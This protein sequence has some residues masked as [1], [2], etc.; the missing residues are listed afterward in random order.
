M[1]ES[2][3]DKLIDALSGETF[4]EWVKRKRRPSKFRVVQV[5]D[6]KI[7]EW[8]IEAHNLEEAREIV[9]ESLDIII[10]PK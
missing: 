2:L 8:D 9:L 4:N 10:E 7:N 6:D 1:R 3:G 5:E